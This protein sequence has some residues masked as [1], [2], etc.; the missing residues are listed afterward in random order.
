M[1]EDNEWF[2]IDDFDKFVE[3]TRVLVYDAF[4]NENKKNIDELSMMLSDLDESEIEEVDKTL[5][6][7]E[8]IVMAKEFVEKQINRKTKKIRYLISNKQY[9]NMIESFNARMVGNLLNDL[10]NRGLIESAYDTEANDFIFWL[11][12]EKPQDEKPETD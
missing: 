9:M 1:K 4:G 3:S 12:D 11:K 6:Q 2:I 10:S 5:T 7:A 8:C